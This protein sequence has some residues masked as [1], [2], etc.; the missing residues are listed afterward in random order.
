MT[1]QQFDKYAKEGKTV[2]S[3]DFVEGRERKSTTG[4]SGN[5]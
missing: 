4:V 5:P 1:K 3:M 2:L